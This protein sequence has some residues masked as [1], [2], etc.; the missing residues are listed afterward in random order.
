[1]RQGMTG[2][3]STSQS[4][5]ERRLGRVD[6]KRRRSFNIPMVRAKFNSDDLVNDQAENLTY[7]L[8]TI[9]EW[10]PPTSRI[11]SAGKFYNARRVSK[12]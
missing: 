6:R 8:Q 5:P 9:G 12:Y 1:M 7:L 10:A 4:S 3:W 11:L 2:M